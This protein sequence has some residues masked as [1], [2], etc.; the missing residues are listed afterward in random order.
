MRRLWTGFLPCLLL[1]GCEGRREDNSQVMATLRGERLTQDQFSLLLANTPDSRKEEILKNPEEKRKF[2][3][4]LLKQ[5]LFSM[6]AQDDGFGKNEAL[7]RRLKMTDQRL[8]TQFYYQ[9]YLGEQDG[10]SR[11]EI[12][13]FYQQHG[14]LFMG[15]SGKIRPFS[16]V[17]QAVADSLLI[18]KTNLDS[19]YTANKRK[20][21]QRAYC[22]VSLIEVKTKKTAEQVH[23]EITKGLE[24]KAAVQKYS[25][26]TS[27]STEGRIGHASPSEPMWDLGNGINIDSVFFAEGTK[28]G[29]GNITKP[30]KKDSTWII[31]RADSCFAENTPSLAKIR[32]QVIQEFI[33]FYRTR[34]TD[35]ALSNLKKKYGVQIR[36]LRKLKD[37]A[38]VLA[39][40]EKNKDSYVSPETYQVYHIEASK[41][42]L[43]EKKLKAVKDLG[44]FKLVAAQ[45]SENTWI[46]ADSGKSGLIKRDHC[47][48]YGIGMLPTLWSAFDTLKAN[49]ITGPY[50][51]PETS[52]WH[53]FFLVQK[54]PRQPK[55]FARVKSLVTKEFQDEVIAQIKPQDTLATYGKKVLLESDVQFLRLEIPAHMQERYTREQLVDYLLTWDLTT[56]DAETAGL[57]GDARLIAQ[58]LENVD[59]Y[60]SGIY[61]DSVLAVTYA[62]DS[63]QLK[64]EFEKRHSVL[65]K[66][67]AEKSWRKYPRDIA[68]L[69]TL[70]EKD[71]KL[72]YA[73]YPERY[74]R[75]S[76]AIPF[77][78]AQYE[79]FQNLK[80]VAYV[81]AEKALLEKLMTRFKVVLLD[82]TLKEPVVGN[83]GEG[84]KQAQNL[85]YDRKLDQALE[86]YEKL[87]LQ[88]PDNAALQDSICFGVAQIYIEQERFQQAMA[89]YRRVSYLYP[90]SPNE[91]KAQ[92]MV[93]FIQSEHL[94]QD[95]AAVRTFETMLKKYP[96]TDLSDDA[97]WMIR[98]IRSGGK[99]MPVLE[100]DSGWVNPDSAKTDKAKP[101]AK[102][103]TTK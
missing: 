97:D 21:L 76:T 67:S 36:D 80:G 100:G 30:F 52:K 38:G 77:A 75:D 99:L 85:H 19:V 51:N 56:T 10:F 14:S 12:E 45:F 4:N 43:V 96:K 70:T 94:K 91:Y 82:S 101:E 5:R 32:N 23:A 37:S 1:L 46:K 24:F 9:N 28:I 86:L 2:F 102:P 83:A 54:N 8:V 103:A 95:S 31:A 11:G 74:Q 20:Y 58:R 3:N 26:H 69:Q 42:D 33:N 92:F 60:W 79:I 64:A 27:K 18:S 40:Y 48:P 44:A 29:A 22:E 13:S 53:W 65:T 61:Q 63:T 88:F 90:Q 49:S 39:Y 73:T 47:L 68:S 50:Q 7:Q 25:I 55:D 72:E 16:E 87:R 93:G 81:R 57:T 98:N 34:L 62:M 78:D 66:D 6:A 71:F 15:D 35:S 89:E 17:R 84:Y 59:S 41:R